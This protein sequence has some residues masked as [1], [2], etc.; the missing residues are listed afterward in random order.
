[1]VCVSYEGPRHDR[2]IDAAAKQ[3]GFMTALPFKL[4]VD[5]APVQF[6]LTVRGEMAPPDVEGGRKVHNVAAGADQ[7]VA[8]ARSF[9]DL[10]HAVYVPVE[11]PKNGSAGGLLLLLFL[12][13]P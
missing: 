13:P 2:G 11:P 9:G 12:K 3:E 8:A 5:P 7:A 4:S 1:F 10:S 6:L